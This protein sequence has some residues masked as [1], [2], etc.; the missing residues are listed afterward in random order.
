[1]SEEGEEEEEDKGEEEEGAVF[2]AGIFPQ[3]RENGKGQGGW[4]IA[5]SAIFHIFFTIWFTYNFFLKVSHSKENGR[6]GKRTL[7]STIFPFFSLIFSL[8]NASDYHLSS[9][10]S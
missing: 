5:F 3:R 4:Q 9:C 2:F 6:L 8:A 1:M 10:S 7:F